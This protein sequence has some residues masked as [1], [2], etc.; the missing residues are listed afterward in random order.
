MTE[1]TIDNFFPECLGKH[2][3]E[4]MGAVRMGDSDF[5]TFVSQT[6]CEYE[7]KSCPINCSMRRPHNHYKFKYWCAYER[8]KEEL[9]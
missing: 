9:R 2:S 4:K 7:G 1:K 6:F 8:K 3:V 5:V